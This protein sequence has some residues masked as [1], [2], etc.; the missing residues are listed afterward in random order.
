M[1]PGRQV[2]ALVSEHEVVI[3]PIPRPRSG[4]VSHVPHIDL[5]A[6]LRS[7]SS[8]KKDVHGH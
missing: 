6:V 3:S 1:S 5:Q 7:K 4:G 8:F 2:D